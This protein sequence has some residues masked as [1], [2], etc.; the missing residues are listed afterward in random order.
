MTGESQLHPNHDEL[1]AFGL[2]KLEDIPQQRIEQHVEDCLE[3]C[4]LLQDDSPEPRRHERV[5]FDPSGSG[6]R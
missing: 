5:P 6:G 1:V 2:G 4:Q 3:C